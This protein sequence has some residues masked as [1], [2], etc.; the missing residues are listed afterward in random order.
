MNSNEEVFYEK[1]LRSEEYK[2]WKHNAPYLYDLIMTHVLEWSSL[3]VQWL[4]I[5]EVAG[6]P[7]M[8]IC[9][10]LLGTNCKDREPNSL[11]LA[12]V[13]IPKDNVL[14]SLDEYTDASDKKQ[15]YSTIGQ[16][17]GNIEI[18]KYI[19][20][21]GEVNRA[22]CMPQL[23]NIIASKANTGEIHIF[24]INLS[25]K[26][27]K[28]NP[29]TRLT[30]HSKE[31][32][33]LAWNILKKGNLLSGAKDGLVCIWDIDGAQSNTDSSVPATN[34]FNNDSPINVKIKSLNLGCFMELL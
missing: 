23:P 9:K 4:P 2:I 3:T 13:K 6:D 22:R 12:K 28:P 18:E 14:V 8:S 20:H 17:C 27:N 7:D 31:G 32:Y 33:G 29:E 15:G 10:L 34:T 1:Q 19:P 26:R 24:D 16:S 30:G 5:T 11:L 25:Y 21:E